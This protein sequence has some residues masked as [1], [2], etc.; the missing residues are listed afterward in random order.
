[1]QLNFSIYMTLKNVVSAISFFLC[2][3][4]TVFIIL[5]KNKENRKSFGLSCSAL[6]NECDSTLGLSCVGTDV[7]KYC[8]LVFFFSL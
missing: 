1:M 6:P 8:V 4:L 5:N 7:S 3:K 2:V